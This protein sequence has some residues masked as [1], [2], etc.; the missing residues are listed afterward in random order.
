MDDSAISSREIY[1]DYDRS[2]PC[3]KVI[4]DMLDEVQCLGST[5]FAGAEAILLW[6]KV[7]FYNWRH[8]VQYQALGQLV[9]VTQKGINYWSEAFGARWVL[10]WF[11]K[12][13]NTCLSPE[14]R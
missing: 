9:E 14:S 13:N 11:Q 10:S 12:G 3:F 5:V 4:L 6:Y 1:E 2:F 8:A 7:M